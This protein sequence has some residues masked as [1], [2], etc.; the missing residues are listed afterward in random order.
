[1]EWWKFLS[2]VESVMFCFMAVV[3]MWVCIKFSIF[4]TRLSRVLGKL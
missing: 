2:A 4:L 1:M 3:V